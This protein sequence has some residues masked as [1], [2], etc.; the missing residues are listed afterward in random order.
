[1]ERYAKSPPRIEGMVSLKVDNLAYRTTI[2]DLRR[3]FSRYGEVDVPG[4]H[5]EMEDV[6]GRFLLG[7][8]AGLHARSCFAGVE[9]IVCS[10]TTSV[11]G[12]HELKCGGR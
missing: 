4:L 7:V 9:C 2:E 1:M 11:R 8:I 12:M 3:V 5:D 6:R 10:L